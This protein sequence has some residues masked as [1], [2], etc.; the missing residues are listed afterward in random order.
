METE[1]LSK[2]ERRQ[3]RLAIDLP[4]ETWVP[5]KDN[6]KYHIS[7]MGRV[8]SYYYKG[9]LE[10]QFFGDIGKLLTASNNNGY[11][12]VN[13]KPSDEVIY[14]FRP[15][16]KYVQVLVAEAFIPNPDGKPEVNHKNGIR[17]DNRAENLEWMTHKENIQ[18]SYE[19]LG[20]KHKTGADHWGFGTT[21]KEST[22][23]L[24]SEKKIGELHPKFKG[25]YIYRGVKFASSYLAAAAVKK[26]PKWV[27]NCTKKG[28]NGWSF[29]PKEPTV[30]IV[31]PEPEVLPSYL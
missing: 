8:K 27:Y 19:V 5:Y 4:G 16:S 28:T 25:W 24:M 7:N 21:H 30:V 23:K 10:N 26:S 31:H 12:Q 18:H 11:L 14:G 17:G 13:L 2:N 20:R 3:L 9:G 22:K 1:P 6:P 15:K 29:M